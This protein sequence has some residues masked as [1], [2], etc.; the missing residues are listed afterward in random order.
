MGKA[1]RGEIEGMV[2]DARNRCEDK[3]NKKSA[4]TDWL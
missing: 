3:E 2:S 1:S 4:Q